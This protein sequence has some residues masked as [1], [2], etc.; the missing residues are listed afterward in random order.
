MK[1]TTVKTNTISL[2][3]CQSI[4]SKPKLKTFV[5]YARVELIPPNPTEIPQIIGGFKGL[6]VAAKNGHWK[7]LTV[8]EAWLNTLVATEVI[9]WFFVGEC[10]G[11][12]HLIGYDV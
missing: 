2:N 10:I 7:R 1:V 8:R 3:Y 6:V 9:C 12:R 11:R 4:A 5:R